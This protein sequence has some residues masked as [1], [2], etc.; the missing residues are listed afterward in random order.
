MIDKRNKKNDGKFKSPN[1]NIKGELNLEELEI[2]DTFSDI[3]VKRKI[4]Q[5]V[6]EITKNKKIKCQSN[7]LI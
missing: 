6:N 1:I 3:K 4:S 7:K 5:E 2:K